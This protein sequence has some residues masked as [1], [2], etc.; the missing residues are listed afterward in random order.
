[1]LIGNCNIWGSGTLY[2]ERIYIEPCYIFD[3]YDFGVSLYDLD[4]SEPITNISWELYKRNPNLPEDGLVDESHTLVDNGTATDGLVRVS[5]SDYEL[6]YLSDD[7]Y[8]KSWKTNDHNYVGRLRIRYLAE[9]YT[10][11]V[12][13]WPYIRD[14]LQAKKKEV[15]SGSSGG[16]GGSVVTHTEYKD[17]PLPVIKVMAVDEPE[18]MEDKVIVI[19]NIKDFDNL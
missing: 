10:S 6:R 17:K 11:N 8:L 15:A 19:I 2:K 3:S 14:A 5:L 1:M 4:T 9:E 18:K 13:N 7:Y 12:A 16:M